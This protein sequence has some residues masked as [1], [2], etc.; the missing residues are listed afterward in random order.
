VGSRSVLIL[1]GEPS[2]DRAGGGLAREL[3]RADPQVRIRAV[4]GPRLR[5]AG[6]EILADIAELGAMGFAEVVRQVPRHLRLERRLVEL[7]ETDPPDVVVPVDYPGF[8][9]RM[10]RAAKT[11]GIRVVYYIGP[12]VWAWGASRV[13]RIARAVDR[14]LVIL[15]FEVEIY[16]R[17]GV[18]VEFVGHPLLDGIEAWPVRGAARAAL[19]V[20]ENA[21]VLGLL[22]GSRVQEVRRIFP[23][24]VQAARQLQ[25]TGPALRVLASAAEGVPREEY[26]RVLAQAGSA[27]PPALVD[28]PAVTLC[29]AAD[30][31]LVTSGTATLEAGLVGTPLAVLYRTSA[32]TWF[33]GRRLVRI[34]R[35][36]LV[37]IVAGEDLAR[38]FLQEEVRADRIA[39]HARALLADP[40]R[41]AETSRRL[42]VLRERLGG[43]GSSRRVA[44]IVLAEASP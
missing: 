30:L 39:E 4:G 35:I 34:P 43:R 12:Q 17:A 31:L 32:L 6:A 18:P 10:A 8:N 22:P 19:G 1:T 14:M 15:P 44:E 27:D 16:E 36:A 28:A 26:A 5:E 7:L 40:A 2:G 42:G 41:R 13:P 9:L 21:L 29:A 25:D 3:R 37:N 24:M 23:V 11:R 33:L 20:P 38:E